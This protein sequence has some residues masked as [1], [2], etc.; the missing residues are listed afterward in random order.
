MGTQNDQPVQLAIKSMPLTSTNTSF[1][2]GSPEIDSEF[3]EG[4]RRATSKWSNT[5]DKTGTRVDG[6][7][8]L[9]DVQT[10]VVSSIVHQFETRNGYDAASRYTPGTSKQCLKENG[11]SQVPD[12]PGYTD[13]E[14]LKLVESIKSETPSIPLGEVIEV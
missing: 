2:T 11:S 8:N 10:K 12:T 14:T 1:E 7:R 3:D 6:I 13:D 5:T 4:S 9:A